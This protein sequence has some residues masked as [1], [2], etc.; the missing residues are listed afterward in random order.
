MSYK[1]LINN[2]QLKGV[3]NFSE[4]SLE[5][6]GKPVILLGPNGVGKTSILEA[7]SLI[8]PGKGIRGAKYSEI[9][10]KNNHN[11]WSVNIEITDGDCI[12]NISADYTPSD[13]AGKNILIN[14]KS[15]SKM[16]SVL[17]YIKMVWV[18]QNDYY[19]FITSNVHRRKFFDRL[20]CASI[21]TFLDDLSQYNHLLEQ[22][23]KLLKNIKSGESSLDNVRDLLMQISKSIFLYAKKIALCRDKIASHF[24]E[25]ASQTNLKLSPIVL[26]QNNFSI[27]LDSKEVIGFIESK[28]QME[29]QRGYAMWG[30]HHSRI[31]MNDLTTKLDINLLSSGEQRVLLNNFIICFVKMQI[32]NFGI[33]PVVLLDDI[34]TFFDEHNQVAL[35]NEFLS[36][37]DLQFFISA[38]YLPHDYKF[39]K[40][41]IVHLA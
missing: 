31:I 28:F 40:C 21:P 14:N 16:S 41:N 33:R 2:I 22:K 38:N 30:I 3:R 8:Y 29:I 5:T 27:N 32:Y 24:N 23:N 9:L 12:N 36:L 18:C 7:I 4:Y 6:F 20:I 15:A 10:N 19:N 13:S 26:I 39:D 37:D 35:I 1:Y 11:R 25:F 34:L 17:E